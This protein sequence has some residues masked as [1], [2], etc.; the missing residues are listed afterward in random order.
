V[1]KIRPTRLD[2]RFDVGIGK[3]QVRD[4]PPSSSVSR[5]MSGAAPAM[6]V[7]PTPVS[8]ERD[9]VDVGFV[10]SDIPAPEPGRGEC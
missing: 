7:L 8:G 6:I 2:R 10:T 4:F 9:L 1:K 3:D 5:V